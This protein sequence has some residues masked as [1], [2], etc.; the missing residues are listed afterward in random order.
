MVK[1]KWSKRSGQS[2]V[3]K[4]KWSKRSGQSEVVKEKWSKGNG[5]TSGFLRLKSE[6][7][8]GT[9]SE[10]G[11]RMGVACVGEGIGGVAR[12]TMSG[13]GEGAG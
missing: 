3:V 1:E 13:E 10:T 8:R 7:K 4:A 5:Q 2:E 9:N 11:E 6:K 12:A